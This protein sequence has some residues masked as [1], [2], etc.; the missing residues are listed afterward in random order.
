[1][2]RDVHFICAVL[3]ASITG[4]MI[5]EAAVTQNITA[6]EAGSQKL[7]KFGAVWDELREFEAERDAILREAN[8]RHE[9]VGGLTKIQ[10]HQSATETR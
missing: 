4:V 6:R 5:L 9:A 2:I 7:R 3:A 10:N 8:V 1:M